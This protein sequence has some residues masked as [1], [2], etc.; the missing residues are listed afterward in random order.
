M[1]SRPTTNIGKAMQAMLAADDR[2]DALDRLT[3]RTAR[4]LA[5]ALADGLDSG[6]VSAR[7]NQYREDR[8][9]LEQ[10][11]A[12]FERLRRDY[13]AARTAQTKK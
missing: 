13:E 3:D 10:G 4:R 2:T 9:D 7:L 6:T 1:S 12:E 11:R 5:D 8:A